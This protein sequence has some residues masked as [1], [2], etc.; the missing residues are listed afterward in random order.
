MSLKYSSQLSN[1]GTAYEGETPNELAQKA[2][3][4]WN[5]IVT[6]ANYTVGEST[7]QSNSTNIIVR[8]DKP[9]VQLGDCGTKWKPLQNV[10]ILESVIEFCNSEPTLKLDR[11]GCFKN[12][13]TI[14]ASIQTDKVIE[15]K[16]G[17]LISG[18][19]LLVNSHD[20]A[21]GMLVKLILDREVCFNQ[22]AIGV[23][24][25]TK[26]YA[27]SK[28]LD[29]SKVMSV[30][31][32]FHNQFNQFKQDAELLSNTTMDLD[33]F[34]RLVIKEFGNIEKMNHI[35]AHLSDLNEQP[36]AVKQI[37]Q[38][39]SGAG[40][41]SSMISA[42]NTAWGA[43]N[44]CTQHV[45]HNSK[46]TGGVE[47]HINSLWLESKARKQQNVYKQLVSLSGV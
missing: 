3:L 25:K 22:L 44:A 6:P 16:G 8:E 9:E 40:L 23:Q 26:V 19:L 12:G 11:V 42:Y 33:L 31:A 15:L 39:Y 41:G 28:F 45:N 47:G 5:V 34:Y 17:D 4:D 24:T 21:N 37:V 36:K 30:L 46:K 18:K 14:W 13:K 10:N 35:K 38:L 7:Y 29:Q 2:G 43:L 27:H 32:G 1:I 20:Y